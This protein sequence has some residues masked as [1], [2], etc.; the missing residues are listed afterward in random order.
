[1]T[2]TK[3]TIDLS[4]RETAFLAGMGRV[5]DLGNTQRAYDALL[6]VPGRLLDRWSLAADW[7]ALGGDMHIA[8]LTVLV[9]RTET[10]ADRALHKAGLALS[11]R[12]LEERFCE[13]YQSRE[14]TGRGGF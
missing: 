6:D 11:A 9:E 7:A 5:L 13:D 14:P 8:L 3:G 12:E 1:M 10:L 2:M 4:R